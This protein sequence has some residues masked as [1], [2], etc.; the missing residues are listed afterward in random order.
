SKRFLTLIGE[1]LMN[2]SVSCRVNACLIN[3]HNNSKIRRLLGK[4]LCC[5]PRHRLLRLFDRQ[6]SFTPSSFSISSQK[7]GTFSQQVIA[8]S[9]K[10]VSI[11]S[12]ALTSAAGALFKNKTT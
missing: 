8:L 6:A 4:G 1:N 3:A 2:A 11:L 7:R 10:A 9:V 5:F 12:T